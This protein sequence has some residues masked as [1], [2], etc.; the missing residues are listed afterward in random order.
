ME[1]T[2]LN[3][4][5]PYLDS[6]EELK[7]IPT[8]VKADF[9]QDSSC[10]ALIFD[11]YGTLIISASGDIDQDEFSGEMYRE[12][13][14]AAGYIVKVEA[15]EELIKMHDLFVMILDVHKKREKAKGSPFP[16][17]DILSVW[18]DVLVE[19]QRLKLIEIEEKSDLKL[20]VFVLE[21][22]SNKVWPMPGLKEVLAEL[23]KTN[24]PLGI[25][26]NAQ[27]YTP[28]IM[29]YFLY[30]KIMGRE[31]LD[32]FQNDLSVFSYK[33]LKGKPDPAIYGVMIPAL[34]AR[35]IKPEEVLF[36][37]NDML[38]DMYAASQVGFRTVFFAGDQRAYRPR[39]DHPGASKVKPD[40]IIT[41]LRQILEIIDE[42]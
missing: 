38:K 1:E 36:I 10:K 3:Y 40:H 12:A 7:A 33:E 42:S 23:K 22:K 17:V 21:L 35:G 34:K 41:D 19:G 9:K 31:F 4:I 28:V 11:I 18:N 26:S 8:G 29:N 27:F 37:G 32:G 20:F 2:Y 15:E 16:E 39:L 13:L 24:I 6:T 30:D 5:K 14:V 25:V